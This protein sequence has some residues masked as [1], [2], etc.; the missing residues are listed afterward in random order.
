M[1]LRSTGIMAAAIGIAALIGTPLL[2]L[3]AETADST[4]GGSI[5]SFSG[6]GT[7]GAVHSSEDKAD[8]AASVFQPNGAGYTRSWSPEV[9]SLVGAQVSARITPELSAVLQAI[10]EQN[11][12]GTFRPHVEWANLKYQFTPDLDVRLGRIELPTFLFSDPRKVGYTYTWVRPPSEVYSL[13]PL[14]ASDGAESSYRLN[15]ADLPNTT[16]SSYTHSKT[17]QANEPGSAIA[18]GAYSLSN[19]TEYGS[20]T[21][22]VSYQRARLSIASIDGLLDDFKTFGPQGIA[23]A[24]K[25]NSDGKPGVTEVIGA[26]YDPGRWFAIGEWAHARFNSF[27]G[28]NTAWYASAGW[29]VGPFTP[30]MIYAHTRAAGNSDPGL[31]LTGLPPALA[32][33]AAGLNASLN[34][35]LEAIPD[36]STV[37]IGARWDF[38]KNLDLKLQAGHM[39]LGAGSSGT[40]INIQ[41]GFRLGSTLNLLSVTVDFVF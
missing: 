9:D 33:L 5:F 8:F 40:L 2:V 13:L 7:V 30:Y 41:P 35:I 36:Q 19:T 25:Y 23:I 31:T 4:A 15:I 22:R 34:S 29:R 11:Y 10:A 28:E 14:T 27:L 20:L 38:M 18:R 12:D 32:A 17:P 24:D 6:F 3:A 39:R 16:Q 1:S 26:S 37:S 21:L